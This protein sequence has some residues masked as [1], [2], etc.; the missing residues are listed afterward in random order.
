MSFIV[1]ID[2]STLAID[3]ILLDEDTNTAE[4][5]RRRLDTAPGDA[6]AR[7]RRIRDEMPSRGHWADRGCLLVAIET[8]MGAGVMAGTVPLLIALGAIVDTLD[9][10]MPLALL[11]S[12][13]WRRACELPA[14]AP[15]PQHKKNAIQF[16]Q[17][18]WKD[19]PARIDDNTADAFCIAWAGRELVRTRER[20]AA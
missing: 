18:H 9:R 17:A 4:H 6:L 16:A 12:D 3:V 1:G 14:R 5:H 13:D 19:S 7:T 11:R 2:Y 20:L 15:R 10:D 8:P